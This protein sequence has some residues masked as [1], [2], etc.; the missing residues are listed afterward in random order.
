MKV[1]KQHRESLFKMIR[2]AGEILMDS[3]CTKHVICE[4]KDGTLVTEVDKSVDRVVCNRLQELFPKIPVLSEE[5]RDLRK[6]LKS[7]CVW[8]FDPLDGTLD[9]IDKTGEFSIML[10]LVVGNE[11]IFGIVYLPATRELFWSHR[12]NGSFVCVD[13]REE[14]IWV[15]SRDIKHSRL[16]VS[17]SHLG[18]LESS[19]ASKYFG[20]SIEMGSSGVKM[21]RIAQGKAEAYINSSNRSSEWD[22]CAATIILQEAGGSITDMDG[23]IISYNGTD[24]RHRNGYVVANRICHSEILEAI[25][26]N[27]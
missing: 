25:R 12:E 3:Y 18:Q 13:G 2:D 15:S 20:K 19:L 14:R 4:K 23:N 8:I 26:S 10:G 27:R 6:R 5:R 24:F 1:Y 9:F 11:P 16:L 21:V 7:E 17:R 22:T